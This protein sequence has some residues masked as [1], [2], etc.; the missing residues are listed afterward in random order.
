M[1]SEGRTGQLQARKGAER[2]GEQFFLTFPLSFGI[3]PACKI[4]MTLIYAIKKTKKRKQKKHC[5]PPALQVP[6][7][8]GDKLTMCDGNHE[9]EFI[10]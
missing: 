10:T 7:R 8:T 2:T 5:Y 3:N 9:K 6:G 4:E 1:N